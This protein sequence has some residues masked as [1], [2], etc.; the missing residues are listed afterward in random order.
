MIEWQK[1]VTTGHRRLLQAS[2]GRLGQFGN[3]RNL[4]LHTTGRKSGKHRQTPLSFTKDG[5]AY[6]VIA[7][8]GGS[9]RPPDWYLN[10]QADDRAEVEVLGKRQPVVATTAT[11]DDRERL[12]RQAV[13]SFA[14]YSG[15][16]DRT[17]RE[18][19]VVRLTPS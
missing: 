15:Y 11:G 18:I 19:P 16:Q 2:G 3:V 9:P 5:D 10:L 12:W 8:N 13:S 14:G 4:V 17:E 7:S 1:A 6:I